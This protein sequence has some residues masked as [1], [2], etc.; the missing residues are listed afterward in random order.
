MNPFPLAPSWSCPQQPVQK[1]RDG[2][3]AP[4]Q[5]VQRR[6]RARIEQSASKR[7]DRQRRMRETFATSLKQHSHAIFEHP[8]RVVPAIEITTHQAR[9]CAIGRQTTAPRFGRGEP[10]P[11][12]RL[13][14]T[15]ELQDEEQTIDNGQRLPPKLL[16][17]RDRLP[18]ARL[19][20]DILQ[21]TL[22]CPPR[23]HA[24]DLRDRGLMQAR[25]IENDIRPRDTLW[26]CE[27]EEKPIRPGSG[28]M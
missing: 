18:V 10:K 5:T 17:G 26:R 4:V 13:S 8:A 19:I 6:R 14:R 15:L 27:R 2:T 1:N 9:E 21:E 7:G 3:L 16:G 22:N 24:E 28:G 12:S 11:L 20:E 25:G 23:L